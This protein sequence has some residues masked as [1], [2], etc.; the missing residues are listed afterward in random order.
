MMLGCAIGPYALGCRSLQEARTIAAP[1]FAENPPRVDSPFTSGAMLGDGGGV[2]GGVVDGG[3]VG[4]GV[5][6]GA[7]T[8]TD[9]VAVA[10]RIGRPS[11]QILYWN[12]SVPVNDSAETYP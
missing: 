4:S 5:T 2:G 6:S 8:S 9:T 1:T 10:H 12:T 11:S 7:R 3:G